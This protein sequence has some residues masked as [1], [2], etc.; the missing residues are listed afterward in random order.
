[1][2]R[3][4]VEQLH[5]LARRALVHAGANATMAST[6]ADALV[7]ADA[8]GLASHGVTRVAQYAAHLMNG[9]ADGNAQPRIVASRGG[10][11]LISAG[12]GLAYPACALAG[13]EAIARGRDVRV[14]L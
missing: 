14:G 6:T 7:Y 13:G 1:M 10:A 3:R 9:R 4:S 2:P 8:R 5:E 12:S 11:A